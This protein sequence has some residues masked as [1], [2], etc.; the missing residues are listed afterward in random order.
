MELFKYRK[1]LKNR[2]VQGSAN[3]ALVAS[4]VV[5][6]SGFTFVKNSQ[7]ASAAITEL[8]DCLD[9]A[10]QEMELDGTLCKPGIEDLELTAESRRSE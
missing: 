1:H 9:A 7:G 2:K 4:A 8:S 6:D 3:S 10:L 5:P